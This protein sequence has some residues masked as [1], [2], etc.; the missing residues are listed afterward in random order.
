MSDDVLI[1]LL[2]VTITPVITIYGLFV[3]LIE[4][5]IDSRGAKCGTFR[6]LIFGPRLRR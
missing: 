2:V 4:P 6:E 1:L 3:W 5:W